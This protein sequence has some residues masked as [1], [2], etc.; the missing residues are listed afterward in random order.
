VTD[1]DLTTK[2]A[3]R[4]GRNPITTTAHISHVAFNLFITQGYEETTVDDIARACGIGRRT[5][6]RYFPSK[7]DIPWGDFDDL[8]ENFAEV[9][10]A[11]DPCWPISDAL[12]QAIIEF[13]TFPA[14]ETPYHRARMDL[15]LSVPSLLGHST[16]RYQRWREVIQAFVGNRLGVSPQS[17]EAR[18]VAWVSLGLSLAAYEQWLFEPNTSLQTLLSRAFDALEDALRANGVVLSPR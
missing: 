11:T 13:N 1:D 12:R 10:E 2:Q 8:L 18:T 17:I 5:L 3:S 4:G 9:L 15:L 7:N 6:F 16:L 14:E